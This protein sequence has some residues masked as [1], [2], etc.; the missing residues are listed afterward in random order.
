MGYLQRRLPGKSPRE[1]SGNPPDATRFTRSMRTTLLWQF[2][3]FLVI[4]LKM[5]RM[6]RKH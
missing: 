3:R 6:V 4:N 2:V 5:L 1:I